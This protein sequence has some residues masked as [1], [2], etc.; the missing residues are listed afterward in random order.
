MLAC[1][2]NDDYVNVG[3][4]HWQAA[5][6]AHK[7]DVQLGPAL[8]TLDARIAAGEEGQYDF[9]FIDADKT[10]TTP[11]TSAACACCARAA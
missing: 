8:Q 10:R 5:G 2:I 1:D 6:V 7:I 11:I 3:R 9:A 4:P